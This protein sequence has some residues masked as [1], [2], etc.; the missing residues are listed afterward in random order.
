MHATCAVVGSS[1]LLLEHKFGHEIDS[2]EAVFR[3][4][5]PPLAGYEKWTGQRTTYDTVNTFVVAELAAEVGEERGRNVTAVLECPQYLIR[6]EVHVHA[7]TLIYLPRFS[8]EFTTSRP[9][10]ST[11][12]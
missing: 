4:N 5:G 10:K 1:A 3:M 7:F 2:H 11:V 8:P 12:S 9:L 6:H